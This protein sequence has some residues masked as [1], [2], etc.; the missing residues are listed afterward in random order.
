MSKAPSPAMISRNWITSRKLADGTEIADNKQSRNNL[1]CP[2]LKSRQNMA[3][4]RD[5]TGFESAELD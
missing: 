4:Q 1:A 3:K 5:K 2:H